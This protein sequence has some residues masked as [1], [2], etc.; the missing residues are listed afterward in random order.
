MASSTRA[1]MIAAAGC[2]KT[3]VLAAA[4]ATRVGSRELVLTHTH[5]GVE[6]MRR[7]LKKFGVPARTYEINT[8]AGWALGL[9]TAFPKTSALPNMEPRTNSEYSAVYAGATRLLGLCPIREVI[10][11]SYSGVYVDEYQDCTVQQH[12]LVVALMD[13]IPCR[14]LGDPLQGIFNFGDNESIRWNEHVTPSFEEL[15][16][17]TTPWRW[18]NSNPRLGDWLQ[19]VRSRLEQG[20]EI[21]LRNAPVNWVD[22]SDAQT[23]QREQINACYRAANHAGESVIA[24][25][26]WPNQCHN[27]ASRLGGCFSCIEAID[28]KDLYDYAL[29]LDESTGFCRST[30]IIDFAA[31]CMTKVATELRT[32]RNALDQGRFPSVRNHAE[33]LEALRPVCEGNS[34]D[35]IEEA[36]R[37]ISK[38]PGAVVYRRELLREMLRSSEAV[39]LGE[40]TTLGAAAWIVR[41]RARQQG[42]LLPRCAVGTTLLVK[43]LEFD[44]AVVLDADVY[45]R[46]NL[47]VA[48]TRGSK[49]LTVV[50]RSQIV[51]PTG[52]T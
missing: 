51:R 11:A 52:S 17:P 31:T 32:I 42:R 30:A 10:R 41:N 8:I 35:R 5:A 1:A 39:R 47:Y 34:V 3:E 44:H 9:A 49:S 40:A 33:C 26:Q 13:I 37:T 50:S 38:I 12:D 19:E 4:V 23:K 43:G 22:G 18:T 28:T 6:A 29:R 16:G 25:H 20:Q 7:R 27:V 14:I 2:G 46:Q 48:L 24:I 21:D 15:A 36:L 45:D